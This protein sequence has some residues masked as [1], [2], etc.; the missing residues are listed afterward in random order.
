MERRILQKEESLDK[1]LDIIEHK[2]EALH[3]KE[4]DLVQSK[5]KIDAFV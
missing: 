5:E 2:E 3:R 1:K 4:A